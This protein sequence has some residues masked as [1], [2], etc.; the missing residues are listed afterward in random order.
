M[1]F[2]KSKNQSKHYVREIWRDIASLSHN[3]RELPTLAGNFS[4]SAD[5]N[6]QEADP[7]DPL[8]P[9]HAEV[10]RGNVSQ[11]R[12]VSDDSDHFCDDTSGDGSGPGP[13]FPPE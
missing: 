3:P 11:E 4:H 8:L 12:A 1:K 2:T 6:A 7:G 5:N 9:F 10:T 13:A